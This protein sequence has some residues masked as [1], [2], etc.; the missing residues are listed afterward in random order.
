MTVQTETPRR[1]G[2]EKSGLAL[3]VIAAAQLLITMDGSIVTVGLPSIQRG[4]G[5]AASDLSWVLTAYALALGGLL[6]LGGRA[7]DLVGRRRMFRIGLAVFVGAS[8]LGGVATTG[9]MMIAARV[10]Q[11]VGAAI[12]A[13]TALSLLAATFPAG[14]AR[15][16]ALGVYGAMSGLGAVVGLLLGGALTEYLSWRWIMFINIPVALAIFA[17]TAALAE[18]ERERGRVDVAGAVTVTVGLVSLVY[19]IDRGGD[20]GWTEPLTLLPAAIAAVLLV[21]FVALQRSRT[22]PMMP[23]AVLGNP[24][25]AGA[26]LVMFLMGG[27]ML[28]T[29]YFLTLYMQVVKGYPPMLTGLAY[30]PFAVG[31]VIGSGVF[32]P[33]LLART[34]GR[35]VTVQGMGLAAAGM[36]WFGL[37]TP[38]QNPFVAL[39]PAQL[40]AGVGL[41]LGFVA[42][43]MAGVR[44]VPDRDTGI[45]S[46]LINTSQQI[47]GALGLAVLVTVATA[48][49]ASRPAG[50][51]VPDALTA[52]YTAGILAGG[53]LYLAAIVVA[54]LAL[55]RR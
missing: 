50:T 44:G 30:L 46:G 32:G 41:G 3:L 52:G 35:N 37:L 10:L 16:K 51:A 27:G 49:T 55:G 4:L 14:P 23:P 11:G 29:F 18:G 22:A 20:H 8:L 21:I 33:Q 36:A 53:L 28:A 48:A 39:L 42:I 6:L 15:N 9:A 7:G 26:N 12:V 34:T 54:V 45:A 17:G 40:V 13:P 25:R 38:E 1:A 47:G 31:I 43:T 24:G 2:A 19:A 5:M